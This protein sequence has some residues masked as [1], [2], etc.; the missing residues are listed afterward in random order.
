M[1]FNSLEF[2]LFLPIVLVVYF[3]LSRWLKL[4]NLFLLISSYVFYAFWDWRFLSLIILSSLFDFYCGLKLGNKETRNR[5]VYL[6]L[7]VLFNLGILCIFKYLDFFIGEFVYLMSG[8]GIETNWHSLNFILPLGISFY[9]FQTMAYTIDVYRK[10]IEAENSILNL[11]LYVSFFPQLVAGPIE[12]A[13]HLLPQITTKR[14]VTNKMILEGGWL[15]FLGYFM[16]VFLADNLALIVDPIFEMKDPGFYDV[17]TGVFAFSFQIYGDFAG[18]TFIAIGVAKWLGFDLMTNFL[19]PYFITSPQ[20][21]WRNW[22]ISLSTWLRDYLYIPLGG[23]RRGKWLTYR[24]LMLTMLLG[25]LWHGANWNFIVWGFYHG[26][27]LI[28]FRKM[29]WDKNEGSGAFG[30]FKVLFMFLLTC[31]GWMLFRVESMDQFYVLFMSL[32]EYSNPSV[33]QIDNIKLVL[34]FI[35]LPLLIKILQYKTSAQNSFDTIPVPL[36]I[37]IYVLMFYAIF[38]F[39]E[40]GKQEFIYFQF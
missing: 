29:S 4:Q 30:Y 22:H 25:G 31:F 26:A 37:S 9:T 34:F 11:A 16:K 19:F 18:Y 38:A 12:R 7:S 2:I 3:C 24:N 27:I 23:N 36:R 35:S 33:S 15:I 8:F 40:F 10:K 5:K 28:I 39:G 1:L 17:I 14:Y 32:F 20:A 21:F 6:I 13:Q